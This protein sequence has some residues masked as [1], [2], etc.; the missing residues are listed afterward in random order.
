MF[1]TL[2]YA[3]KLK[4]AGI[5]EQQARAHA[6][7]LLAVVEQNFATKTDIELLRRDIK[8][9]EAGL[10]R[11]IKELEAGLQRDIKELEAGLRHEM[12]ELES[13]ITMRLGGLIV[14]GV[15]ALA[16][17]IRIL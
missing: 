6:E 11:D 16:V 2:V 17:L 15:G 8:E 5:P 1:D 4:S 3:E 13:R 12:K 9:L 7:G 14:A 10:Q